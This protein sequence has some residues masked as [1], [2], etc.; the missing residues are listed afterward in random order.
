MSLAAFCILLVIVLASAPAEVFRSYRRLSACV[1]VGVAMLVGQ[2]VDDS[3]YTYPFVAWKMYSQRGVPASHHIFIV[4][5]AD[6][7]QFPYPFELIEP[8]VS[9]PRSSFSLRSP[10]RM[11]IIRQQRTCGCVG[12]DPWLDSYIGELAT[13]LHKH[14]GS[15]ASTF[16]LIAVRTDDGKKRELLYRW[17]SQQ[18]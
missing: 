6:G 7:L 1:V 16:D 4:T 8:G 5:T 2:L 18:K 17:T 9:W 12:M 15:V 14:R 13:L 11:K 10:V 3:V